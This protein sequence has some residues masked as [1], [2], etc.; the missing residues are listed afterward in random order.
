MKLIAIPLVSVAAPSRDAEVVRIQ[1]KHH[2]LVRWA[3]WTTI[4]LLLGLILSGIFHL[5]GFAHL[6]TLHRR[7]REL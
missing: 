3:H 7:D 5:L 2:F 4:P 1:H 6:P